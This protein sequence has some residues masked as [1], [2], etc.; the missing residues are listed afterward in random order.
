MNKKKTAIFGKV[1]SERNLWNFRQFFLCFPILNAVRSELESKPSKDKC[2]NLNDAP[3]V[4]IILC[5]EKDQTVVKYS[6]LSEN[7]QL[8]AARYKLYLP[9]EQELIDEIER[10]KALIVREQGV[11][12]G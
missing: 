10:E 9:T 4:G 8:F 5:T 1:F 3:T 7:R 2:K 12:Y 6:V 11:R